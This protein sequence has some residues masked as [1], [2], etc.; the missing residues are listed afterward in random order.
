M[1]CVDLIDESE[2]IKK[3]FNMKQQHQQ[4]WQQSTHS[5]GYAEGITSAVDKQTTVTKTTTKTSQNKHIE[6]SISND[7]SEKITDVKKSESRMYCNDIPLSFALRMLSST[8]NKVRGLMTTKTT[9]S[10]WLETYFPFSKHR[11]RL[12]HTKRHIHFF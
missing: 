1:L 6:K 10:P 8:F 4:Q 2:R 5:L 11:R 9:A 3:E 12:T 7:G